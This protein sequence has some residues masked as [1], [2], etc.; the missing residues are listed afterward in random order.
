MN[1]KETSNSKE[2]SA[3]DP[4][5]RYLTDERKRGESDIILHFAG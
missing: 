1:V 3:D 4:N 2:A 5:R